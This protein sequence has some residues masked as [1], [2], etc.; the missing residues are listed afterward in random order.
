M[1]CAFLK[2]TASVTRVFLAAV[3]IVNAKDLFEFAM[4]WNK[5][6][7]TLCTHEKYPEEE[8]LLPERFDKSITISGTRSFYAVIPFTRTERITKIFSNRMKVQNQ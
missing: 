4:S 1:R 6:H 8:T 7:V 3:E 2:H 5:I